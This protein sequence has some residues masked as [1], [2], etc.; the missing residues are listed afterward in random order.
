MPEITREEAKSLIHTA[1][2][3]ATAPRVAVLRLLTA[4]PKPLSH[5]EVITAVGSDDWDQATL[6]RNLLKLVEVNLARVASQMGGITRYETRSDDD[7][8]VHPHFSCETCGRVECL[9]GAKLG[10]K[11]EVRWHESLA[12]SQLQ[13]IGNCPD[14]L[15]ARTKGAN[16]PRRRTRSKHHAS[17]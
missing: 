6:Y 1:G 17:G 10:G 9:P 12:D 5:S 3:R 14:C 13:L 7:P 11:V 4:S 8:H 16:G 2:L 15:E